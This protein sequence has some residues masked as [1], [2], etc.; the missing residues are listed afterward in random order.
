MQCLSAAVPALEDENKIGLL[1]V[2]TGHDDGFL[3]IPGT[4]LRVKLQGDCSLLSRRDCPVILGDYT[5][6]A[7]DDLLYIED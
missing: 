5:T 1:R 2:V 4:G 7:G 3:G 6:S